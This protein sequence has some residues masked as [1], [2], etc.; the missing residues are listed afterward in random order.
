MTI[1]GI[2]VSGPFAQKNTCTANAI[3]PTA[4][5]AF[6][7]TFSPIAGG[8]IS[9]TLTITDNAPDSPQ[10]VSLSG[11]GADV[12]IATTS[13]GMT[14]SSGGSSATASVQVSSS[15]S[16]SGNVNLTCSV[17]YQGSGT[18]QDP[19]TCSLNPTQEQVS[20]GAPV[21]ATL[22]VNTTAS[23]GSARL[24]HPWLPFG[25]GA[26]AALLFFGGLPRRRWRKLGLL[27]VLAGITVGA[28]LGCGGG[29]MTTTGSGT[30]ANP[31]TTAGSYMVTVTATSA[32][33]ATETMSVTIPLSVQ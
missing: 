9:G 13:T 3:A 23:S 1:T 30:P 24:D 14:V 19:P 25:G 28:T 6:S 20:S 10:T 26:L 7:V 22:T 15:G 21:S 29:S 17:A 33:N 5:C 31:G 27:I 2:A 8:T 16:F 4:T 32:S 12:S 11:A 18:A